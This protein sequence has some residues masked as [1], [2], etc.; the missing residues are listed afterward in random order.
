MYFCAVYRAFS[1]WRIFFFKSIIY[2]N[3]INHQYNSQEDAWAVCAQI[4][5]CLY[6]YTVF[7]AK[8][9]EICPIC[10]IPDVNAH[11]I[12]IVFTSSK[13]IRIEYC[14]DDVWIKRL[15]LNGARLN[16]VMNNWIEF[17]NRAPMKEGWMSTSVQARTGPAHGLRFVIHLCERGVWY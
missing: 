12:G 5:D 2:I 16:L 1:Y 14:F 8:K 4:V 13:P 3:I 9:S 10:P 7:Q 17:F 11:T 15:R 6:K